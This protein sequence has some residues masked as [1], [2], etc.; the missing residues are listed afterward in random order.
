MCPEFIHVGCVMMVLLIDDD[1]RIREAFARLLRGRG[2]TI[3]QARNP[4]EAVALY[5]QV[6]VVVSD[7]DMPHGGG[8]RVMEESTKPVVFMTG[9]DNVIAKLRDAGRIVVE[10]PA[11]VEQLTKAVNFAL[12]GL[13]G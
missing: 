13:V 12:H 2:W 3:M 6:H 5:A 7:W 8:S 1:D 9:N 4:M 10:K 11:T